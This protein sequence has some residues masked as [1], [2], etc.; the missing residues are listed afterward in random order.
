M[1]KNRNLGYVDDTNG[2]K[3]TQT[4]KKWDQK[5]RDNKVLKIPLVY[6]ILLHS[7]KKS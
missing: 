3:M 1:L 7:N 2:V 5:W 4:V 6:Q